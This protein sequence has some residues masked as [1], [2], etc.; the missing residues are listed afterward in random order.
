M[1]K[2]IL[3]L[4]ILALIAIAIKDLRTIR[5]SEHEYRQYANQRSVEL[6]GYEI[7][8]KY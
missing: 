1:K 5:V 6:R 7:N 8:Q 4:S 2:I 3:S